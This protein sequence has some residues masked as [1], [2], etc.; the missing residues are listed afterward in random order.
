MHGAIETASLEVLSKIGEFSSTFA[1]QQDNS[2]DIIR[3][4]DIFTTVFGFGFP[5]MFNVGEYQRS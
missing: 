5:M 1:P 2:K 3:M 4:F